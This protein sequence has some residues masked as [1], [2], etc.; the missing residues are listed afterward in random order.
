MIAV[1]WQRLQSVVPRWPVGASAGARTLPP[2]SLEAATELED[3]LDEV[4]PR[5]LQL[6][7]YIIV[8][9]LVVLVTLAAVVKVDVVVQGT[10]EL[11]MDAQPIVL[12]PM[13]RVIIKAIHVRPGDIVSK[14][15]RLATLDSTFAQAD[16]AA[17]SAQLASIGSSV[18]RLEAEAKGE[19]FAVGAGNSEN[20]VMQAELFNQRREQYQSRL[21]AYDEE[22]SR[23]SA[24]GSA[25]EH[26]QKFLSEQLSIAQEVETMRSDLNRQQ[27]TS[28]LQLLESQSSRL[29]A[30]RNHRDAV[31]RGKET[32]HALASKKAERQGFIDEWRRTT[33]EELDRQ[34]RELVRVGES[35]QKAERMRQLVDVMAP[36]DGIVLEVAN[37]SAG[38]ILREAEP[39]V[40]L[41]PSKGAMIADVLIRSR[42]VGYTKIG[43]D[44]NVKV[45]AFPYQR[46]GMLEGRLRSVSE[47][48]LVPARSTDGMATSK[49]PGDSAMHRARIELT[50]ATL[51]SLPGGTRILP[52]MT[53]NAEVK[54]G[55]RSV[56]SYFLDPI[57][58]GFT[59]SMREPS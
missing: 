9:M 23:I 22:I 44:V 54:I 47:N 32:Q 11:T 8:G 24:V 42:D 16:I 31:S 43:D 15:Q 2:M 27:Y 13:E 34:R 21:L 51:E 28:K 36:E 39:L 17:L 5:G 20:D 6:T 35:V 18:R 19:A 41:T 46:H 37:R 25:F 38:S 40:T 3:M 50:K 7:G 45:D 57:R 58:R 4:P 14:G 52:G 59:E 53:V 55:T 26:D 48:T 12:Q 10:G 33:L 49:V 1:L 29:S 30:E 56:L